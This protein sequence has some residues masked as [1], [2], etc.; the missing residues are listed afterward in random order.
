VLTKLGKYEIK[1][2]LGRGAMGIVYEGFDPFIERTVAIKTVQ[3]SLIDQ[4]EAQEALSRFRREAQA[5]GRLTHPNIVAVYEYAEEDDMAFIAMEFILGKEL[6]EYFDKLERFQIKDSVHIMQQIL[7]ALDYAHD[8]GVVHRDIKPSNIIITKDSQIKVVDFGIARIESS[9]LTQV[10]TV[11]GTP[12][13]M[14][15]EQFRGLLAD[16]RSD[17]YSSGVILYQFLT[18][19]RPFTGN[20]TT[21]MHKVLCQSPV[22]PSELNPEVSKALDDVVKKAMSKQPEDRFQT[23]AEFKQALNMATSPG[24]VSLAQTVDTDATLIIS[25]NADATLVIPKTAKNPQANDNIPAPVINFDL[26]TLSTNIEKQLEEARQSTSLGTSKPALSQSDQTLILALAPIADTVVPQ[27]VR[28]GVSESTLSAGL[29]LKAEGNL[30]AKQ[31]VPQPVEQQTKAQR[32]HETLGNIANFLDSLAQHVKK[33]EPT[34]NRSYNFGRRTVYG[35]LTCR[36][37]HADSRRLDPSDSALLDYV[38]LSI[39]LCAPAP[40]VI[41]R[42]RDML[43]ALKDQLNKLKL[44]SLDDLD[45]LSKG[46]QE[47]WVQVH[48]A[49][50]FPMQLRFKGNYREDCIDVHTNN[51]EAFGDIDFKLKVEDVTPTL[52]DDIGHFLLGSTDKLPEALRRV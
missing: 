18:G 16:R 12:A 4:S 20:P 3:K 9:D 40:L 33:V 49:P 41:S 47:E 8:R 29:T 27:P 11:L 30:G 14:S 25:K 34:I 43:D 37:A 5:A 7:D 35:N 23:A 31:S 52:L 15:P 19:D 51:I 17:I 46:A 1:R 26:G 38:S 2:E 44:H 48:L 28:E 24:T 39:I 32:L 50:D 10:G 22:P 42:P 13:Y 36:S 6:K 45:V 21:L